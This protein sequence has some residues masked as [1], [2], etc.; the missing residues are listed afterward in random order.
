MRFGYFLPYIRPE[1]SKPMAQ[2]YRD[3]AEQIECIEAAGFDVIWFPEHHFTHNYSSP[4]PLISVVDAVRRTKRIRVG[5]S[6][7]VTPFHHPLI[8]AERVAF[9]DHLTEGRLEIGFARGAS[10]FEYGRLGLTDVEA[11]DRQREALEILLGVWQADEQFAYEGRY[12]RFP[13]VYVVPRPLQQPHPPMWIAARTP[14]TLRFCIE[15]GLGLHTTTLRQ[16]MTATYATLAI[17]DAILDDLG[18]EARPPLAVQREAFA[19]ESGSAA[20]AR[21]IPCRRAWS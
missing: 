10:K 19:S 8:L 6:V 20:T 5:T 16:P 4:D 3:A 1:L 21:S 2:V 11:A 14:E 18:L 15:R 7:I 12:Y 13:S 17:I 9:A